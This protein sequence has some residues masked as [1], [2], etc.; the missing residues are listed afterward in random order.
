MDVLEMKS[1]FEDFY[2][3]ADSQRR[4]AKSKAGYAKADG[5]SRAVDNER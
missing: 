5:Q 3:G 1:H 2:T 4:V